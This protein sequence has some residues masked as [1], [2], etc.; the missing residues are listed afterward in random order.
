[1][2]IKKKFTKK[3]HKAQQTIHLDMKEACQTCNAVI[4][5]IDL[6]PQ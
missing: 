1:M 5:F 3:I 4:S 2:I 6:K